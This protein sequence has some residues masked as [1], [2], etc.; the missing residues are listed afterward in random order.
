MKE[1]KVD[2]NARKPT[3]AGKKKTNTVVK[4]VKPPPTKK[5]KMEKWSPPPEDAMDTV[6]DLVLSDSD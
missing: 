5:P 3:V 2:G 6:Q 4:D 1:E